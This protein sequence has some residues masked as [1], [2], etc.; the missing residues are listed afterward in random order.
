MNSHAHGHAHGQG[1]SSHAHATVDHLANDRA[2]GCRMLVVLDAALMQRLGLAAD[3]VVRIATERG[4]SVLARLDAPIAADENTGVLRMDRLV[5][6]ALKAHLNEEVEVKPAQVGPAKRVELTPAVDVSTAHDI[7]P[8][9]K[10]A[11]VEGRTPAS[12][13]A[14]LYIP[15]VDSP[16]GT[17]YE[18]HNVSESAGTVDASTE[19]VLH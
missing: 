17:T 4:R 6:Q 2:N 8:H 16:A 9:L 10:R 18:I 19:V 11:M 1:A 15:F 12:T 14:V 5:R 7:V 3:D 13:G